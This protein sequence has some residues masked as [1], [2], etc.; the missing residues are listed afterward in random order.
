M[1][2]EKQHACGTLVQYNEMVIIKITWI[3]IRVSSLHSLVERHAPCSISCLYPLNYPL[4]YAL[5]V[6]IAKLMKLYWLSVVRPTI[7]RERKNLGIPQI[8]PVFL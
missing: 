5:L 8:L 2:I 7:A 1:E 6:T 4:S 3:T